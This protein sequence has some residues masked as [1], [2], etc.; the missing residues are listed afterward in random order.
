MSDIMLRLTQE[1]ERMRAELDMTA[2]GIYN[3]FGIANFATLTDEQKIQLI[4]REA[5]ELMQRPEAKGM[6]CRLEECLKELAVVG[7][8]GSWSEPDP[9][10]R[11]KILFD[12]SEQGAMDPL[13]LSY[14]IQTSMPYLQEVDSVAEAYRQILE[15][16]EVIDVAKLTVDELTAFM[17]QRFP[18]VAK[19]V[20][21]REAIE[22]ERSLDRSN[23]VKKRGS[24][25]N[26]VHS[27]TRVQNVAGGLQDCGATSEHQFAPPSQLVPPSQS[28]LQRT[29]LRLVHSL[30]RRRKLMILHK[31]LKPFLSACNEEVAR[32][33][34]RYVEECANQ[35]S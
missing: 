16:I 22:R 32:G 19:E 9:S 12:A 25:S 11:I 34:E 5:R 24:V 26:A 35:L 3:P 21:D 29:R 28:P 27:N 7:Q 31:N 23:A 18:Q 20:L 2:K 1:V 33:L 6:T 17:I 4:L 30:E 10:S 15:V 14:S 8:H 13:S